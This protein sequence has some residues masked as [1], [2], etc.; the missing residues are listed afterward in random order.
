VR[1]LTIKL[2]GSNSGRSVFLPDAHESKITVTVGH[3]ITV[4][5]G[6]KYQQ[7]GHSY[8]KVQ[9]SGNDFFVFIVKITFFRINLK[10]AINN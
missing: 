3:D 7:T 9:D 2:I 10:N 5:N 6:I 8:I 1:C 4:S